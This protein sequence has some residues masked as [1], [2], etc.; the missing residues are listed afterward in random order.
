MSGSGPDRPP[1][2]SVVLAT[3]NRSN[4]LR[5]AIESVQLQTFEDWE[6]AP[7]FMY[8]STY[9][10][11]PLVNGYSGYQ[12]PSYRETAERMRTFPDQPYPR[13]HTSAS[14]LSCFGSSPCA[15]AYWRTKCC[16]NTRIS[17]PRSRN[18]GISRITTARR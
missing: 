2:V 11:N 10:W 12:P 13:S 8:W 15:A 14:R 17:A 16:A 18:G 7:D 3:Y 4:V 5:Y 1:A 6:L 9:H